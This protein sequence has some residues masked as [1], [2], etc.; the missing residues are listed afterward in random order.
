[1]DLDH[2]HRAAL[3]D[4]VEAVLDLPVGRTVAQHLLDLLIGGLHGR[5]GSHL[6]VGHTYR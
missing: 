6:S 2:D 4:R 3:L 1:M 5:A